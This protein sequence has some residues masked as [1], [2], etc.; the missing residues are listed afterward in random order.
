M[1]TSK[2]HLRSTIIIVEFTREVIF[3]SEEIDNVGAIQGQTEKVKKVLFHS[4]V[5]YMTTNDFELV[6]NIKT[7]EHSSTNHR[8]YLEWLWFETGERWIMVGWVD[9]RASEACLYVCLNVVEVPCVS[10]FVFL[11]TRLRYA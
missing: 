10:F 3:R 8:V 11:F 9:K 4:V 5:V 2:F 1:I 6:E 7:F